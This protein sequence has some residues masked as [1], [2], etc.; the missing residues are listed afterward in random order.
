[1]TRRRRRQGPRQR[2]RPPHRWLELEPA[3]DD[4]RLEAWSQPVRT[5]LLEAPA[6]MREILGWALD[7]EHLPVDPRYC[8]AWMQ[9]QGEALWCHDAQW[10]LTE[11]GQLAQ[12]L[13]MVGAAALTETQLLVAQALL[14]ARGEPVSHAQLQL[15]TSLSRD[16]VRYALEQLEVAGHVEVIRDWHQGKQP[17]FFVLHLESLNDSAMGNRQSVVTSDHARSATPLRATSPNVVLNEG[18]RK[19]LA[20]LLKAH[21]DAKV[22]KQAGVSRLTVLRAACGLEVRNG[23]GAL[24]EAALDKMAAA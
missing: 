13:G 24:I 19:A 22:A 21:G 3:G 18:Q 4:P 20:A 10:H 14:R 23:S 15:A 2:M 16:Q 6:T 1:M 8:V 9:A 12:Q 11:Q 17:N 5:R 7:E